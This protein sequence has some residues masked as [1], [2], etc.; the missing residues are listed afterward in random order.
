MNKELQSLIPAIMELRKEQKEIYSDYLNMVR[1][2]Y[3]VK[4]FTYLNQEECTKVTS[5]DD[6]L[7]IGPDEFV[8]GI[9]LTKEMPLYRANASMNVLDNTINIKRLQMDPVLGTRSIVTF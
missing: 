5:V 4:G 1:S 2:T 8:E 6:T 9:L 7:V 3:L